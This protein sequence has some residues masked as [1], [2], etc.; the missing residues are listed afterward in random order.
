MIFILDQLQSLPGQGKALHDLCREVYLPAAAE[1][2]L[3]LVHSLVSPPLW[4]DDDSNMLFFLWSLP[5]AKAFWRKNELGRRD[6]AVHDWWAQVD[7]LTMS[8][9]RRTL[10]DPADFDRLAG[11]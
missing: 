2:G 4:L 8:R 1:R 5:D 9:D 10:A 6:P 7:R 11:G 3:T